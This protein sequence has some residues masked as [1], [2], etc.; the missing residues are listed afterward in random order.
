[1]GSH[2]ITLEMAIVQPRSR[3]LPKFLPNAFQLSARNGLFLVNN[4]AEQQKAIRHIVQ[5]L[6]EENSKNKP[7]ERRIMQLLNELTLV[8]FGALI[9]EEPDFTE[10]EIEQFIAEIDK[11]KN[12]KPAVTDKAQRGW[13][14]WLKAKMRH[15]TNRDSQREDK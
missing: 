11:R 8:R 12:K 13:I 2:L 4:D 10:E 15:Y 3:G 9:P 1:M 7:D 6:L 14:A 5:Q